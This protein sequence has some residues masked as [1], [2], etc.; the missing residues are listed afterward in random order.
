MRGTRKFFKLSLQVIKVQLTGILQRRKGCPSKHIR[1]A[2]KDHS[3]ILPML[4]VLTPSKV[5]D[6]NDS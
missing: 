4:L 5:V 2:Y 1:L 6:N 3:I